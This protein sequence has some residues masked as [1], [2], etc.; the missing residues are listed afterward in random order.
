MLRAQQTRKGEDLPVLLLATD[1]PF[2]SYSQSA[3]TRSNRSLSSQLSTALL[4]RELTNV[5]PPILPILNLPP[6]L[7]PCLYQT[8]PKM[9]ISNSPS[10][11]QQSLHSLPLP[12]H[13]P[14]LPLHP[15]PLLLVQPTLSPSPARSSQQSHLLRILRSRM[16][17]RKDRRWMRGRHGERSEVAS[18]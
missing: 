14:P 15:P 11:R 12:L 6:F 4:P 1:L 8:I 9:N 16:P 2:L 13:P 5:L 17:I 7:P 3:Y 18:D 10:V